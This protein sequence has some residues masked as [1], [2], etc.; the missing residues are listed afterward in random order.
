[1][2]AHMD[3]Q[4]QAAVRALLTQTRAAAATLSRAGRAGLVEDVVGVAYTAVESF[5]WEADGRRRWDSPEHRGLGRLLELAEVHLRSMGDT[6]G[7]LEPA[8]EIAARLVEVCLLLTR[9]QRA[10]LIEDLI[11]EVYEYVKLHDPEG[12]GLDG[13]DGPER[14]G[15]GELVDAATTY[16]LSMA[17]LAA[18][19]KAAEPAHLPTDI[20]LAMMDP[21][22]VHQNELRRPMQ[23]DCNPV[24]LT[25]LQAEKCLSILQAYLDDHPEDDSLWAGPVS[26]VVHLLMTRAMTARGLTHGARDPWPG[27]DDLPWPPPPGLR[28][29]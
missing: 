24:D 8:P 13:R 10:R 6:T 19:A 11:R 25:A 23:G 17:Q 4:T 14:R 16:R 28:G 21:T 7:S 22:E 18:E 15:L 29:L 5:P 2:P 27:L 3:A 1:M 12:E 26:E 20:E 9:A